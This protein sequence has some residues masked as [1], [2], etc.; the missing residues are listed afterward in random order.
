MA[1]ERK[2]AKCRFFKDA[3]IS[4]NGW[5]T[6]PKRQHSSDNL[7]LVRSGELAC[8]NDWGGDLFQGKD[9]APLDSS[10]LAAQA[11]LPAAGVDDE[12][13]SVVTRFEDPDT[14]AAEEDRVVSDRP[15]PHHRDEDDDP[16]NDAAHREQLERA[17]VIAR[18][19][20]DALM[21]ARERHSSRHAR[22]QQPGAPAD[23]TPEHTDHHERVVTHQERFTDRRQ[24]RFTRASF[25][26]DPVPRDEV[27][28]AQRSARD[29][30]ESVPEID[31]NFDLPGWR[32][33]SDEPPAPAAPPEE[34]EAAPVSAE[35]T[36]QP[37]AY[38]SVLQR[39]RRTREQRTQNRHR[40]ARPAQAEATQPAAEQ[41]P[42]PDR[43]QQ[44]L[45]EPELESRQVQPAPIQQD[46]PDPQRYLESHIYDESQDLGAMAHPEPAVT[47]APLDDL[48]ELLHESLPD[49]DTEAEVSH[50]ASET[51][52]DEPPA[53]HGWFSRFGIGRRQSATWHDD[54]AVTRH[55]ESHLHAEQDDLE[56]DDEP[57]EAPL[58]A[59][60]EPEWDP[61]EP[62]PQPLRRSPAIQAR[63]TDAYHD[64]DGVAYDNTGAQW[65]RHEF[66]DEDLAPIPGPVPSGRP[67]QEPMH[68]QR[69][70][71]ALPDL[72]DNLFEER[73]ER[74]RYESRPT[75]AIERQQ[76]AFRESAPEPRAP[77]AA[78][79]PEP[80][81]SEPFPS[82]PRDSYFRAARYRGWGE[83]EPSTFDDGYDDDAEYLP[84][85]AEH[86]FDLREAVARGGELIDMTID[87]APKVPRECRT[88][89]SFRSADGGA[90]GWCTNEWAFTHRRMVNEDDLACDSTVGC[91]WLP[92]DR[93][94][95]IEEQDGYAATPRMDELIARA[96]RRPHE[97]ERQGV[98]G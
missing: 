88:C 47:E 51:W 75:R 79:R 95:L 68:R 61:S 91:W 81:S 85:I 15:V 67:R 2:C 59:S 62:E 9:D 65:Y 98:T 31:P 77:L 64:D 54:A 23:D 93:Y 7:L 96:T 86:E 90:R 41:I 19:S 55:T 70:L 48:D 69:Q 92:A 25:G 14:L 36:P 13:T 18:G 29:R 73:F 53:R 82:S 27:E 30:F 5:C 16:W 6:H 12:V 21:R 50:D 3:G 22:G 26:G 52:A 37:A 71:D 10:D 28:R 34:P 1:G 83:G 46:R 58:G 20:R 97:P 76:V 40:R 56:W 60:A 74:S 17:H 84:D 89:R 72:D 49:W 80:A 43:E 32:H 33:A 38:E 87:I 63:G 94:W 66:A 45:V 78:R 44:I 39:A 35:A 57:G 24:S 8:R 42:S 11:D 4:G